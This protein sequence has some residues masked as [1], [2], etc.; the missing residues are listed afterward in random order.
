MSIVHYE[1][2]DAALHLYYGCQ[3][4]PI[5]SIS[6]HTIKVISTWRNHSTLMNIVRA[7][8]CMHI[9]SG[10]WYKREHYLTTAKFMLRYLIADLDMVK[11]KWEVFS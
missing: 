4:A 10:P 5:D 11:I 9:G 8:R 2:V 7:N 6:M 3:Q 1:Q